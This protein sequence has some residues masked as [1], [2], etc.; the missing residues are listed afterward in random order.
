[1]AAKIYRPKIRKPKRWPP[2]IERHSRRVWRGRQNPGPESKTLPSRRQPCGPKTRAVGRGWPS[3]TPAFPRRCCNNTMPNI[4]RP[5]HTR[6]R[7]AGRDKE[8]NRHETS[9]PAEGFRW[10]A[11]TYKRATTNRSIAERG[12]RQTS[13]IECF[14]TLAKLY[15]PIKKR[16]QARFS[17]G[18][19][20][21]A[22]PRPVHH[23]AHT[24]DN[25]TQ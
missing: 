24:C 15:G 10:P 18:D 25:E 13:S 7:N 5:R 22:A 23:H 6:M 3:P 2:M 9:T 8:P 14:V 20:I 17:P 12:N 1:M 21:D 16:P 19:M 4:V 11:E